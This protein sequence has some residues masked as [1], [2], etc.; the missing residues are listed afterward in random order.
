V[1][2]RSGGYDGGAGI[3]GTIEATATRQFGSTAS[4]ETILEF[5]RVQ[6]RNAGWATGGGS[7]IV[8]SGVEL[9]ICAWHKDGVVLRLAFWKPDKWAQFHQKDLLYPTVFEVDLIETSPQYNGVACASPD[10]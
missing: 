10:L 6:M 4:L 8:G 1:L 7:T 5:Y 3:D 2:V 9:Q